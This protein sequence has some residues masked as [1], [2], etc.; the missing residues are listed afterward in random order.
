MSNLTQLIEAAQRGDRQT[1]AEVLPLIY[2]E[3]RK[4]AAAKMAGGSAFGRAVR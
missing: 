3:L 1:A 2:D 4:L